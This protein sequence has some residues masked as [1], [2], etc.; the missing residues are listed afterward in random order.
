M[1]DKI[2]AII[3]DMD[4]VLVDAKDWHYEALNKALGLFG[5]N[6]SRYDHL[7]T[8]D[9][10]PTR[11]KLE[12]FSQEH[13]L[14]LELHD[15]I[16]EMKQIYTTQYILTRCKPVFCHEYAISQLKRQGYKL[17]VC[18]NAVRFS[19]EMMMKLS[20]LLEYFDFFL[21]NQDISKPKPHP[22]IYEIAIKKLG[23]KP[24]ECLILEDNKHGI[25]AAS[26]SGA[27]VLKVNSIADVN[28]DRILD[29]IKQTE[30]GK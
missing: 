29:K 22:E 11:K 9:G 4:G 21:S 20:G 13:N 5:L 28:Y 1:A 10:L 26:A 18:S 12:M 19:V 6:I 2:K 30:R 25:E 16:C 14:P 23:L 15:F 8:F 3:F 24:R 27:H 17:A 7:V